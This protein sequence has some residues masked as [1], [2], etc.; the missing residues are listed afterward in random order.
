MRNSSDK[1][2]YSL[3]DQSCVE[4]YEKS[5]SFASY[6]Q[7]RENLG[8]KD[9][10]KSLHALDFDDD[11]IFHKQI[12]TIFSDLLIFVE[13]R[14]DNLTVEMQSGTFQFDRQSCFVGSFE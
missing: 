9:G 3:V 8:F 6:L 11:Y 2:L 10:V 12:D 13:H 14:K 4:V 7:V 5:H 1:S